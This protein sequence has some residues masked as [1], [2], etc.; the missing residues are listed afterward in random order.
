MGRNK[1]ILMFEDDDYTAEF[2]QY[3]LTDRNYQ[4]ENRT[5]VDNVLEDIGGFE[6][7]IILMDLRIPSFG[8][9]RAT[10]II[11]NNEKTRHIPV[12]MYSADI[13]IETIAEKVHA[14]A[15]IKKPFDIDEFIDLIEHKIYSSE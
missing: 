1:K 8:G 10:E 2:N 14:D 9:D 12:I 4:V 13:R 11:K 15:F 7:D 6:P 3:L 5:K